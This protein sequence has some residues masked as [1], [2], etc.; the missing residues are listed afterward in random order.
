MNLDQLITRGNTADIYL[1]D[2]KIVKVFNDRLPDI[3]AEYEAMKQR[4]AYSIGIPVPQ[5][6]DICQV[7][8]KH[9]IIMEFINGTTLGELI[10]K[11]T[12]QAD[13]Y[14]ALSVDIQIKIHSKSITVFE[15]MRD[16]LTWQ[17][18]RT[19]MLDD[20]CRISLLKKLS[21]I[22]IEN[23]LC[24]G[25]FHAFNLIRSK[26]KTVVIDWVD[27]SAGSPCADVYRSYLLYSQFSVALAD[28]YL[29]LYCNKSG[30][31]PKNI[32]AW[33]P[34]IAGARLYEN[35]STDNADSLLK[36]VYQYL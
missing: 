18:Q 13:S 24:H 8:G 22:P 31:S 35:V 29:H 12:K 36:I 27:S 20:I 5:V 2:G 26:D 11:D 4:F 21:E 14:L 23:K 17:L 34:V 19:T 6:F 16:R 3:T 33:A 7:N 28:R 25:D 10:Q 1:H 30:M 32:F 9:A 15:S